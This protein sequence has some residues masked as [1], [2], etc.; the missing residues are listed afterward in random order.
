ME[1]SFLLHFTIVRNYIFSLL[2][3]RT[4]YLLY[5]VLHHT[6]PLWE[7]KVPESNF[8]FL[9]PSQIR[10]GIGT[11]LNKLQQAWL[12]NKHCSEK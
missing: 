5:C 8:F 11:F 1:K 9:S 4:F 3:L 6:M 2:Y 12:Y 10:A 7:K